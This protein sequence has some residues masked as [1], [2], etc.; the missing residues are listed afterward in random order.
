[1]ND[2]QIRLLRQHRR[3]HRGDGRDLGFV[4]GQAAEIYFE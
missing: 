2:A 4:A 1:M 3:V